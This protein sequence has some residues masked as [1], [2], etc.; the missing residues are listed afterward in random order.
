MR[1]RGASAGGRWKIEDTF[2]TRPRHDTDKQSCLW[3][4]EHFKASTG[5]LQRRE[6]N[7]VVLAKVH[8]AAVVAGLGS[9]ANVDPVLCVPRGG[10]VGRLDPTLLVAKTATAIGGVNG[11]LSWLGPTKSVELL[12]GPLMHKKV[13]QKKTPALINWLYQALPWLELAKK[14]SSE[15]GSDEKPPSPAAL[16]MSTRKDAIFTACSLTVYL[17]LFH[18]ATVSVNVAIGF[19][20]FPIL[21]DILRSV[22]NDDEKKTGIFTAGQLLFVMAPFLLTAYTCF[23]DLKN[24]SQV[25]QLCGAYHYSR[26]FYYFWAPEEAC[27]SWGV[28]KGEGD[29]TTHLALMR[30]IGLSLMI[31]GLGGAL[32]ANGVQVLR[33]VGY[34]WVP[35]GLYAF[36]EAYFTGDS[37]NKP[38]FKAWIVLSVLAAGT[39]AL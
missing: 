9:A 19:G 7:L 16:M 14:K 32:L 22:L 20:T 24:A 2:V 36:Y 27:R 26:G 11:I 23:L 21:A 5:T 10:A 12:Y 8:V 3:S 6:M 38:V 15:H 37:V 4:L 31:Y 17:L 1:H 35:I 34:G 29:D 18:E 33:L 30:W 25:V 39:L 28:T 13:L